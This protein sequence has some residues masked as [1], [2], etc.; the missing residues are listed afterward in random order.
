M[1]FPIVVFALSALT[2][3]LAL[4]PAAAQDREDGMACTPLHDLVNEISD[5]PEKRFGRTVC[6]DIVAMDQTLVYNR[7]GSFNPF[8]MMYALRRDVVDV[9]T[10][11]ERLTADQCD[12]LTGA[13][14]HG[15]NLA[16]GKVRLKDCKRPRP[17][18]LRANAG[19]ILHIRLTNL[20]RELAPGVPRHEA[21][22]DL[23]REFCHAEAQADEDFG[24]QF[25]TLRDWVSWGEDS[26]KRHDEVA[27]SEEVKHDSHVA[28]HPKREAP[29]WPFSRGANL[30]I[31]GLTAFQ[32]RDGA[33][34]E[35]HDACKGLGA[36]IPGEKIDCY[37]MIER[38][39]P[40]FMAST[41][42]PAGGQ[43]DGGSLVHGL[44]GAVVA[45]ARGTRWYRSQL[46]KAGFDAA[47]PALPGD[48]P[49]H[50]RAS[51]AFTGMTPYE[52]LA[53]DSN[54][55]E[56]IPVL[57]MLK[58]R[59]RGVYEL[60]HSD[61]NAIVYDEENPDRT[62]REFSVFFHDELKTFYSRNFEELGDFGA[63]QLAGVRDGFAINYGASG[64]GDML[65]ANRKGIGPAANCQECLYE[66]FFLTSWANGDP[67]LL[68]Q[69]SDD[70]SNVHHSY[71]NDR[72][73]FRNFHAGPKETHV[74]HLHAHQWFAGNDGGRGSYLDS[75]TVAPQQGFTYDIY[76]GGLE[77]YH[78]GT[79]GTP[80]W[81]ETLG[82]GNR[83][84]T[85]GDSIFH[86]HLYPHFAQG[87]WE[88]WRVHD[89]LEDGTRKLP[90]GQW[91]PTLSLAEM[92]SE[93]RNRKRPGSVH[94]ISGNWIEPQTGLN[95]RQLGTP[96]P[97]LVP[98]PEQAWPV[99]PTYP[100]EVA[101]LSADGTVT[102]PD[103]QMPDDPT[104]DALASFPGY[105]FY[106]AAQP[107]H[108]PPQ[109]PKDIARELVAGGDDVTGEYLDGGLPRHVMTD[110]STRALPFILPDDAADRLAEDPAPLTLAQALNDVDLMQREALQSQVVASALA[111]GD[112]TLK[113]KTATLDPLP[114]DGTALERS[115]MA[116]HHKGEVDGVTLDIR[117]ADGSASAFDNL[118]GGYSSIG[119]LAFAVNGSA[120][121]PGAPFAD[122][123]GAPE[124]F[125]ALRRN[126]ANDYVWE[127]GG[128][129]RP[130]F[131]DAAL[132]TPAGDEQ[133]SNWVHFVRSTSYPKPD[134]YVGDGAG[135][136]MAVP[137]GQL[138]M[139]HDPFLTGLPTEIPGSWPSEDFTP[140]P[141]VIGYR[142]YAASA[143]QVDM[144]TNRAGWHDPQARINVL[145]THADG[146][147][148]SDDYKDG[149]GHISPNITA[150]EEP[151]FFRAL[152]GE[153]IEFRHTNELPKE[154]E[155]DDFQVKTPTDT[156]GQHIHLVKF[157]VTSSDGSGNGF[158]YEDGTMAP[159]EI[160]A[161]ICAAKNT[162]TSSRIVASR[163]AGDL[164]I[165]EIVG[166]PEL[167]DL[168]V[169]KDGLWVVA[170]NYDH[171]IW[172]LKLSE[173]RKLFQ[174]TTQRWFADPILSDLR[175]GDPAQ[176]QADRTLRTVFSHDHFG[177]S[178]IQQHGFYTAL[179]IEPQNALICDE[180]STNCTD[181]RED[182]RLINASEDDVGARKVIVDLFPVE[183]EVSDPESVSVYR[184]F[185]VSIADFAT[186]YE[187]RAAISVESFDEEMEKTAEEKGEAAATKGMATLMCEA[188]HAGSPENMEKFCGSA[189]AKDSGGA[190]HSGAGDVPPAWL[191]EGRLQDLTPHQDGFEPNLFSQLLIAQ[192]PSTVDPA[193]HLEDHLKTYRARAAGFESAAEEGARLARPVSPPERPE[194][195]SVDHHDPYL[196]NYRGQPFPIRIGTSSSNT[197]DCNLRP[198]GYWVSQLAVGV[199]ENCEV[200]EQK[201]GSAGD[202]AHVLASAVD[203]DPSV[204]GDPVV[205]ILNSFD[206]DTLQ[207]R[208]IQGAQ[209]VQHTFNVE[210]YT[211]PRN[212]DQRF[213]SMMREIDDL[214]ER[215]TLVR[216]CY[217]SAG[218]QSGLR[219]ARVGRPDEYVRWSRE[220]AAAFPVGSDD[221]KFWTDMETQIARCFNTDGRIAAQEV[222]ISEHFEFKSAFLY[223][224]NIETILFQQLFFGQREKIEADKAIEQ[225]KRRLEELR[226]YDRAKTT[227]TPYHFGSQDA[228]WNGAWGLIRVRE[229]ASRLQRL[230][231]VIDEVESLIE[232]LSNGGGLDQSGLLDDTTYFV[233]LD[234]IGGSID[235]LLDRPVATATTPASIPAA[236][237]SE[238]AFPDPIQQSSVLFPL[239]AYRREAD[240]TGEAL[241]LRNRILGIDPRQLLEFQPRPGVQPEDWRRVAECD[242][243]APRVYA[244][245]AAIESETVFEGGP[246]GTSYSPQLQDYDGLFFALLD[247]RRLID[248]ERPDNV[249]ET[250]ILDP[251]N[252]QAIPRSRVIEAIKDT[253]HR[254][255]PLVVNVKA[256]DCVNVTLLNA[257]SHTGQASAPKRQDMADLPGDAMMPGIT[258]INT[259]RVWKGNT[260]P[261]GVPVDVTEDSTQRHKDIRPSAR[262]AI[263][264]PLPMVTRQSEVSRPYGRNETL[265]L[266]GVRGAESDPV[267]TIR[268][269]RPA[270]IEQ[271]E[272][273]AGLATGLRPEAT[274]SSAMMLSQAPQELLQLPV[275]I[276]LRLEEIVTQI[277]KDRE[278]IGR[279]LLDRVGA[280]PVLEQPI[281][282]SIRDAL[283]DSLEASRTPDALVR[284]LAPDGLIVPERTARD[285]TSGRAIADFGSIGL[286]DFE[287]QLR[288]LLRERPVSDDRLNQILEGL[289]PELD[290]LDRKEGQLRA[291]IRAFDLDVEYKPYAFGAL[292]IKSFGDLIGH[293]AHG[294][295][296]AVTVAPH[297]ADLSEERI[298]RLRFDGRRCDKVIVGAN[299]LSLTRETV[300]QRLLDIE[301]GRFPSLNL[302]EIGSLTERPRNCRSF[303]LVPRPLDGD[304]PHATPIS[305]TVLRTTGPSGTEHRIRQVTL[306]WQDGLNLRD[307][308]SANSWKSSAVLQPGGG[309]SLADL[310][311][312]NRLLRDVELR[313]VIEIDPATLRRLTAAGI[314]TLGDLE[315]RTAEGGV[316]AGLDLNRLTLNDAAI[317]RIDPGIL[318]NWPFPRVDATRRKLVADCLVCDDSYDFGENGI[319]YRSEPFDI[320][321]RDWQG[322]GSDIERH[323]DFN[324]YEYGAAASPN[325]TSA[326]FFRL[327]G[328]EMP[329]WPEAPI[330]VVRAVEGEEIVVHVVHPGGRARQRAFVTVA[331]DYDDLFPGF[332]FPRGALLAP[333]KAMTASLTKTVTPGCYLFFDGP[334]HLRSGGVWGLIDVVSKEQL[335]DRP[336][337]EFRG[338]ACSRF[339]R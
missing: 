318:V 332:G 64:M 21:A 106:I 43:G 4:V 235:E 224:T 181:A 70:P 188:R 33:M 335:G 126:G 324:A 49:R 319:S 303:V 145:T 160:A 81:Y 208:L 122:P 299:N 218:A 119:G 259:D 13:E 100:E 194:S 298:R 169:Q 266:D 263:T 287:R 283:R 138:V 156:I 291:F 87:M 180:T 142:R 306:F 183:A 323:Y 104:P 89:V 295:I 219:M 257:L 61:L 66:E 192:G 256:G 14:G 267:L 19:D 330:P 207:F 223:D 118:N 95:R 78:K 164:E 252:W 281:L 280:E 241:R 132:T 18:T 193:T 128:S 85:V 247:P 88:L 316:I 311:N 297:N 270:Q 47:F 179:V 80:G 144:V 150:S 304:A 327:T 258:S 309:R 65:L 25:H 248:P 170:E 153:C 68:E 62:F 238:T 255:E 155:L 134:V 186:L 305:A 276:D 187:P 268:P 102:P 67:A 233:Y 243:T 148:N 321:L 112:L 294:L 205:P 213:P 109:A 190:W 189:L 107:G 58:L 331:Q 139:E 36:I 22:P 20:L 48:A 152:S 63:G 246:V 197:S 334:T 129:Q 72:V 209:E 227:D 28:P 199:T 75:Q 137:R 111:L 320:R 279:Q 42:A 94:R 284:R 120:P 96:I 313:Q 174:T 130:V 198:L 229:S 45:E 261:E 317:A 249:T 60:V 273:Y 44:F 211:W 228:L 110:D 176:G 328:D 221:R 34:V 2:S 253:Y 123:C 271:F 196:V 215:K 37:Y 41:G 1:N 161:R 195:I 17:L 77:V 214:T 149:G 338:S 308:D 99:L 10:P 7:F 136:A 212:I 38:E 52:T 251:M 262:L 98:L 16:P 240:V 86:C 74:F 163:A 116:F 5:G 245:I 312:T 296:G 314:R 91:E 302:P 54:S 322:N 333:G 151:F 79:G 171:K 244:A 301:I 117:A 292:P 83:N 51:A 272:F 191:A 162:A 146:S 9:G 53:E 82:S 57:N 93:I 23:S 339:P 254:P 230:T 285:A 226:A 108:R 178:S 225:L 293:P 336:L 288:D 326:S 97:A 168:C 232:N 167:G 184:E 157:D 154:L 210:G 290:L 103:T 182:R 6:A 76:E 32:I 329:T 159:G 265:A 204:H 30:A 56:K 173:Y 239:E 201:P 175:Q 242:K 300:L 177:P 35:A 11:V 166:D 59:D 202:M 69:F 113:L 114:Y 125:G 135:G 46:T 307:R 315:A 131:S 115:G 124:S 143:V 289:S 158:N 127:F 8:G 147:P 121:K 73:V 325:D 206:G 140:D 203:G 3:S 24:D 15:T 141:A 260:K 185:A 275:S 40:F 55:G 286:A 172:E 26:E 29:N 50:A 31:Q 237:G 200:S 165:R 277:I 12:E 234:L 216:E 282:P 274:T 84:R 222:G 92:N 105:P 217:E 133:I 27:C 250:D 231:E 101:S 310:L 220:G 90:D 236:L 269:N 71:L 264:L 39:G 278:A 337:E